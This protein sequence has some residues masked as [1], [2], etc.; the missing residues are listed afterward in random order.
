MDL[1][2]IFKDSET[3]NQWLINI[4]RE[5]HAHPELDFDLPET[6]KIICRVLDEA[7]VSYKTGI[8]KSGITAELKGQNENVTIALRADIDALPILENTGCEYSSQNHGQMHGCGHDA[9]TAVLLGAVKILAENRET[10]PCNVRFL[11]QPAEETSGGAFPMIQDGCLENVD[12]IFGLHVDP[13]IDAGKI[14]IKYGAMCAS[15]TYI[16]MKITG[17]SCHGAYPSEGIDAVVAAAHVITAVQSVVSRNIDSRDSAVIT[18]GSIRGGEKENIVAQEV[19]CRG[20]MRT[21]SKEVKEKA[22]ERL[23]AL[24]ENIALG[25]GAEGEISFRD[26]YSA[27]INHDEYVN[28]IKESGENI[29]T[30]ENIILKKTA[31]MGVED[32]AYYLEKVPGAFFNLGVR[33]IEKGITAPLH[34]DKF[35]IDESALLLGVKIQVSNVFSAYEKLL[36]L[37]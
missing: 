20:T 28:I 24:V 9:H 27:L 15:S 4:R 33:N 12:A 37:K 8:G 29:L 16:D 3:F 35:N 26:S 31:D 6:T 22:K 5:L 17:K 36:K 10:L 11:F 21:L 14:G 32:F 2:N 23:T 18:F 13:T 7:E 19:I 1:K 30:P 25:F 34:N